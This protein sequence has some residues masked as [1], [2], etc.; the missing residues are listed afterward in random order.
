M[1]YVLRKMRATL[2]IAA[3]SIAAMPCAQA[4]NYPDRPIRLIVPYSAGGGSDIVGRQLAHIMGQDLGQTVVVENRPGASATIG[5]NAVAKSS[6]DGYTLLLAD[7]P[8]AINASV[9]PSLPYKPVD[10]FTAIAMIG[11]TPLVLVVNPKQSATTLNALIE[12][13][14]KPGS[15]L[16]IASGGTG[17]LT[18]LVG[19]M[20][21]EQAGLKLLH[22]PYKG[23]GQAL[24]DV[25]AGHVEM[26]ISTAP[27]AIPLIKAGSLRALAISGQER[28]AFLPGVPTFAESGMPNFIEY[29][30]YGILGPA[31]MDKAVVARLNAAVNKALTSND[32]QKGLKAAGVEPQPSPSERLA[33]TIVSDLKKWTAFTGKHHIKA[34]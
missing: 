32:L 30:W 17:T 28:S 25:V 4:E 27:G 2:A 26:M 10:D 6:P 31:G 23:T 13:A 24:G 20:M 22:I 21:Q 9:L 1:V 12:S 11:R 19:A 14:K 15:N 34:D 33:Q 5:S 8:H 7:S 18:H 29:T 16:N 3:V